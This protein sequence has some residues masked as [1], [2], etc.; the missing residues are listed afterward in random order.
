MNTFE[1]DMQ[2]WNIILTNTALLLMNKILFTLNTLSAI[3]TVTV[4]TDFQEVE[5]P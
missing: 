2:F 3:S 1:K 5:S 4:K